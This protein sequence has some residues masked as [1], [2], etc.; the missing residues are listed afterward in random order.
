MAT[1]KMS[2]YVLDAFALRR[3]Y[4]EDNLI[5]HTLGYK[6]HVK[7]WPNKLAFDCRSSLFGGLATVTA[8]IGLHLY[9]LALDLDRK[10]ELRLS[11]ATRQDYCK[12]QMRWVY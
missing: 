8:K 1:R 7:L 9:H 2:M 5:T 12:A 3:A 10:D 4:F 6:H 11:E